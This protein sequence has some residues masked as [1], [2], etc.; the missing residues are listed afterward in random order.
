MP[1]ASTWTPSHL[2]VEKRR[3]LPG[4]RTARYQLESGK[5]RKGHTAPSPCLGPQE[6]CP[7]SQQAQDQAHLSAAQNGAGNPNGKPEPRQCQPRE[8]PLRHGAAADGREVPERTPGAAKAGAGL[9]PLPPPTAE[10]LSFHPQQ[11]YCQPGVFY[12]WQK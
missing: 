9:Q 2:R 3:L 1:D 5:V 8:L 4:T 6:L 7:G 10:G 12:W 11:V